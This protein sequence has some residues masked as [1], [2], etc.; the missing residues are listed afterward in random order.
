MAKE[1]LAPATVLIAWTLVVMLALAVV[2]GR[3]VPALDKDKL[4]QLPR[5]GARGVDLDRVLP[6]Q[7]SWVGHNYM[8]LLEQ[9]TLFYAV[10]SV[11]ALSGQADLMTVRLA[12]GYT[13]LRIAHSFWQM[14][15]NKVQIRFLLFLL[16]SACLIGLTIKALLAT[17]T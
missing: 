7:V 4:K 2:R 17:L 6:G 3:A 15:V 5:A 8:H 14:L 16:S 12:W 1:L 11:L 9:P 10:I 13:A